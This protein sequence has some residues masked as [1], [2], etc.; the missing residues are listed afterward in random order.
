MYRVIF[1][2]NTFWSLI[3]FL[4]VEIFRS[5]F[6]LTILEGLRF[7][8]IPKACRYNIWI[9]YDRQLS[10]GR[11]FRILAATERKL[12]E[13]KISAFRKLAINLSIFY[14]D[15][16]VNP[17]LKPSSVVTWFQCLNQGLGIR[18]GSWKI[19]GGKSRES[20]KFDQLQTPIFDTLIG[21]FFFS[22]KKLSHSR[23]RETVVFSGKE[24]ESGVR[25]TK[26]SELENSWTDSQA[27]VW[28]IFWCLL[29]IS[30]LISKEK[31]N[32]LSSFFWVF[33]AP[34]SSQ[35]KNY[36]C[37]NIFEFTRHGDTN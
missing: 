13:A 16:K 33:S 12:F 17:I 10:K 8:H 9:D 15:L 26:E 30:H 23:S 19:F 21:I 34:I 1:F 14:I 2:T 20:V 4:K 25:I 35:S 32:K 29:R 24:S 36:H 22:A 27:L 18:V 6:S 31:T 37:V 11:H 3:T 28:T 7:F 5:I